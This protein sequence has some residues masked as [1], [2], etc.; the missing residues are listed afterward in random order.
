MNG[1]RFSVW[2]VLWIHFA[3][4]CLEDQGF[5]YDLRVFSWHSSSQ[6][7]D[8]RIVKYT[9][10]PCFVQGTQKQGLHQHLKIAQQFFSEEKEVIGL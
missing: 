4:L 5:L 6:C 3:W 9:G 2:L 8:N 1:L 7:K 10:K